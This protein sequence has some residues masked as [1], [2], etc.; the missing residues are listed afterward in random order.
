MANLAISGYQHFSLCVLVRVHHVYLNVGYDIMWS[1]GRL[2]NGGN[3]GV[4]GDDCLFRYGGVVRHEPRLGRG[5]TATPST[6]R[7]WRYH[8][9]SH[10]RLWLVALLAE[11]ERLDTRRTGLL[12]VLVR[13]HG[14]VA[15]VA[16]PCR[17]ATVLSVHTVR[18]D[19]GRVLKRS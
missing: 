4:R 5:R 1:V 18:R 14:A 17:G 19:A 13:C 3:D 10:E 12:R 7:R 8:R 15:M 2:G 9:C 11:D 16:V 6:A